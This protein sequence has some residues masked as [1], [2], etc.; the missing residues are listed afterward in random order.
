ML[1][2]VLVG[3]LILSGATITSAIPSVNELKV[4][5]SLCSDNSTAEYYVYE[6]GE[7][8]KKKELA[9]WWMCID[10]EEIKSDYRSAAKTAIEVQN[11]GKDSPYYGGEWIDPRRG[12]VFVVVTDERVAES[13]KG[14]NV[15]VVKG[16]YSYSELYKW[17]RMMFD[18]MKKDTFLRNYLSMA[19][20]EEVKN[21]ILIG[22]IVINETI[23]DKIKILAERLGIPIDA[24]IVEKTGRFKPD[25]IETEPERNITISEVKLSRTDKIRPMVGGIKIQALGDYT[26]GFIAVRNGV[27]GFVTAGHCGNLNNAVY[28]PE[29]TANPR[30]NLVGRVTADPEGPRHSDAL[31]VEIIFGTSAFRIF[32]EHNPLKALSGVQRN[33]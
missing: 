33:A 16:K 25:I 31:F 9:H 7:W 26:L 14:K 22:V 13:Y 4:D 21:K 19:G 23:L 32:N 27:M 12:I 30:E 8:V 17:K 24:I 3:L 1:R 5:Q 2:L 18:E 10:I 11:A 20:P 6:N 28:Q 15:V 29:L